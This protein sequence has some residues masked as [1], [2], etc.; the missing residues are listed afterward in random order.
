MGKC[1]KLKIKEESLGECTVESYVDL[2]K[3]AQYLVK[4]MA[5]MIIL[6]LNSSEDPEKHKQLADILKK[7]SNEANQLFNEDMNEVNFNATEYFN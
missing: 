3:D 2:D 5:A 6:C 7:A 4:A 1:M